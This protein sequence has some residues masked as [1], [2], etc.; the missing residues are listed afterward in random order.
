MN[1]RLAAL[2][3]ALHERELAAVLITAAPNRRYLSGF[4]GSAGALLITADHAILF[5]D[6]RYLSRAAQ[7]APGW[8]IRQ[9][10][11][12]TPLH[13]ALVVAANE[14]RLYQIGCEAQHMSVAQHRALTEKIADVEDEIKPE[15]LPVEH[16]VE[17]LRE[18]K[19]DAEL[20]ILRR[21]IAITDEAIEAVLPVLT[22]EHTERQAAWL[23]E[24]A[25]R[26]RG[27]EAVSFPIIVAAGRNAALPHAEAGDALL[28]SGQPIIIDMGARYAGY[29]A[30]LTRTIVLGEPDERF[31][32]IYNLVLEAQQRAI[33]AIRPGMSGPDADALARDYLDAAG[34][35]EAF[36]HSLGHGVG[37]DIHEGPGLARTSTSEVR[38][39]NVFSVEPGIYLDDWGGVR[40]E[41]LALLHEHGC[42]V[43]S[44]ARKLHER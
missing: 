35:G 43:L 30:D 1:A 6:F 16:L 9:I 3:A 2:R 25:L 21:A 10:G 36:G 18:V 39:G 24:V 41:D 33:A 13:K 34:F 42:E 27:A 8:E 15:L 5:T 26:E 38:V 40:I 14:L 4:S 28:G 32:H 23:L 17:P 37:L 20:T 22:S 29:H 12:E 11:G 31:W 7:E 44:R 19:D